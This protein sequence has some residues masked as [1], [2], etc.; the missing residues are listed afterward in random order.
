MGKDYLKGLDWDRLT[1]GQL[2]FA[3]ATALV[4]IDPKSTVRRCFV[5][6]PPVFAPVLAAVIQQRRGC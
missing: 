4:E 1:P 3:I 2:D 6:I 5:H